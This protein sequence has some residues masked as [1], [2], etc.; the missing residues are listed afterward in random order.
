MDL[1][2]HILHRDAFGSS[3]TSP[4]LIC[5]AYIFCRTSRGGFCRVFKLEIMARDEYLITR[6]SQLTERG[7][8]A[9][10]PI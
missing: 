10:G 3:K 7:L 1:Q 5:C 4:F 6:A 9:F 2:L 8:F